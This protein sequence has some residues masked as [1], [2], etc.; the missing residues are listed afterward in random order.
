MGPWS[1]S[2]PT[3]QR[4]LVF[5]RIMDVVGA[6]VAAADAEGALIAA[7]PREAAQHRRLIVPA[8]GHT[9]LAQSPK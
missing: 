3:L 4:P 8:N 2:V 9:D 1:G 7:R 5:T 6:T